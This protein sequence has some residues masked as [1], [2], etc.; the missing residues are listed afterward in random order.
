ML[1]SVGNVVQW[2]TF[3]HSIISNVSFADNSPS[4]V[5]YDQLNNMIT[6]KKYDIT[7]VF[8][9]NGSQT[10]SLMSVNNGV[11][12]YIPADNFVRWYSTDGYLYQQ[13][14]T[15]QVYPYSAIITDLVIN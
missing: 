6:N 14:N 13:N 5:S 7:D 1:E 10:P 3:D 12:T 9:S 4:V 8:T 11:V 2:T 15:I